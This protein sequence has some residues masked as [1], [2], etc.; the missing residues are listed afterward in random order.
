M[1]YASFTNLLGSTELAA[2]SVDGNTAVPGRVGK[3]RWARP[4]RAI[5]LSGAPLHP[6]WPVVGASIVGDP[7][8]CSHSPA[9][10]MNLGIHTIRPFDFAVLRAGSSRRPRTNSS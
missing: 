5:W 3:G 6:V 9:R 8:H 1:T 7:A 4:T 2:H 10:A